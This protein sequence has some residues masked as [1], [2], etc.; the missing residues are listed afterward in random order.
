VSRFLKKST[1]KAGSVPGALVPAACAEGSE[2]KVTLI[3][4]DAE[5]LQETVVGGVEDCFPFKD[6]PTVT[7]VN[8]DGVHDLDIIERMGEHFGI[9]PLVLEDIANTG[10]RP[11]L[12]DFESYVFI[13]LKMLYFDENAGESCAEQVSMLLGENYVIS[14][15]ERGG[16]VFE[17][18]RERI[19]KNKGRIRKCG[20]DYLAYALLDAV[21][22]NYFVVLEKLGDKIDVMEDEVIENPVPETLH[23][24]HKIKA[25]MV[26]LRKSV[27][28]LREVLSSM[29]RLESQL[30]HESTG[31]YIRDVYD[32]TI[33]VIDTVEALKDM[34]GGLQDT[35]LASVS[36][37]MTEVSNRMNEVMKV[38]TIFASIFI[39]LTFI[40]GVY[41]M[42]FEY[43]PELS[44]RYGYFLVWAVMILS[45]VTMF[46][47]FRRRGWL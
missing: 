9:H 29:S 5:N 24:I 39:P 47:F 4:Y 7:W 19:R 23:S 16:D 14:F 10:Q 17:P 18:V 38:L 15:Q 3:D 32:H 45:G 2:V 40:A 26:F 21:V 42:N 44:Y 43:M 34:A 36:N 6:E 33:Q 1:K 27:W 35:Y 25:D 22:D 11:K 41:G 37:R 20:P 31:I 8:V 12:E 13:V 28:P 30:V 46:A